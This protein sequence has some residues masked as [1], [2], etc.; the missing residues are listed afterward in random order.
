[1]VRAQA[2]FDDTEPDGTDITD[3]PIDGG[4]ILLVIA[5]IGFGAKKLYDVKK[6]KKAIASPVISK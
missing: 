1:M 4:I 3:S 5:G 6:E 2:H